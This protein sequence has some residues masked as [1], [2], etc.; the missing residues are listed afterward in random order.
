MVAV[1]ADHLQATGCVYGMEN[2]RWRKAGS[3]GP[4]YVHAYQDTACIGGVRYT[5]SRASYQLMARATGGVR[6]A[7]Y[8]IGQA[9]VALSVWPALYPGA[10]SDVLMLYDGNM[11]R[12]PSTIPTLT[13]NLGAHRLMP[14]LAGL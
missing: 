11:A 2:N 9:T 6:A 1:C 3:P 7:E 5:V 4:Q 10:I 12:S 8:S 13:P 14:G